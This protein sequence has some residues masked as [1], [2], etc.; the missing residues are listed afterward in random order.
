MR[1]SKR[2]MVNSEKRRLA[3][4]LI[5]KY[6][7]LEITSDELN[8]DFPQ[9]NSDPALEAIWSNLWFYYSDR[10][11]KAEGKYELPPEAKDLFERCVAFL[12]TDLEYEWPPTQWISFKYALWRLL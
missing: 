3:S 12:R 1:G 8:D 10:S 4:E 5:T 2:P 7:S 11:H 6:L 9:D